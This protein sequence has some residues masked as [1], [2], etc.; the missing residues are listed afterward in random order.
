MRKLDIIVPIRN[1]E[2]NIIDLVSQIN[3]SF[4]GLSVDYR[5]LFVDDH[6]TDRSKEL[7][8]ELS[9]ENPI[10]YLAKEGKRGKA[11]SILE[12]VQFSDREFFAFIDGDLQYPPSFIP[13]MLEIC[14]E[15]GVGVVV[16]NRKEYKTELI[17]K[18][19][20]R[21]NALFFGK[22]LLGLDCDVQSGLKVFRR[23]AADHID[24]KF[25]QP[26]TIDMPLLSAAK[27]LGYGI[28]TVDITFEER[29]EGQSKVN[30]I[31][32][33]TS[34]ASCAVGLKFFGKKIFLLPGKDGEALG[35]GVAFKN[36]RYVTHSSLSHHVSALETTR[37]WQKIAVLGLFCTVLL[38]MYTAPYST[39]VSI[40]AILSS[41]YFIDVLFNLF[42]MMKSLHFPPEL[43]FSNEQISQIDD[44]KLPMYSILCPLYKEANVLPHFV[45]NIN[46]LDWPKEKL[47]VMLLLEEDDT[48][49]IQTAKD[50]GLPDYFRVLVVPHSFPKTKPKACNY[51][52]QH[53]KGDFLVIYDAEDKPEVSQLKKAYLGFEKHGGNSRIACLQAKLNYYNPHHNILTRLFTAEYSLWFDV[54]LPGFQSIGTA[55]PLGGTSNHF[56]THVLRDLKG[57]D[58]FNVTEDADL[59]MRLFRERYKTAVIDST[60]LEEPN[61]NVKNWIRQRSRWIK[62]YMQTYLVHMRNPIELISRYGLHAFIFQL[63]IGAR[64]YFML[65]NPILWVT[66]VS[67]FAL[68]KIVGPTIESLFPPVVFYM[69]AFSLLVGNF[70]AFY[71]YMIGC[72]K[73]GHWTLIKYVFLVPFYWILVSV[74]AVMAFHQLLFKP[75]YWEKTNHGL[76]LK[77]KKNSNDETIDVLEVAVSA[78]VANCDLPLAQENSHPVFKK[79]KSF[80]SSKGAASILFIASFASSAANYI[81]NLYLARRISIEAFGILG[82]LG[83]MYLVFNILWDSVV[84]LVT[85]A[86]GLRAG[87]DGPDV[88]YRDYLKRI[89]F[90]VGLIV[91]VAWFLLSPF[92]ASVFQS[93]SVLPIYGFSPIWVLGL[94][95]AV[96][97]G[98]LNGNLKFIQI[99]IIILVEAVVKLLSAVLFIETKNPQYVYLSIPL[100]SIAAFASAYIFS[101]LFSEKNKVNTVADIRF[102]FPFRLFLTSLLVKF[103]TLSYFSLD[104]IIA[105]LILS[106]VDSGKY[107]LV[108]VIG[109]MIYF[110][111][112]LFSQFLVPYVSN[113][114]GKGKE[115]FRSFATVSLLSGISGFV[116]YLILGLF[117]HITAPFLLGSSVSGVLGH[118]AIAGLGI[119]CFSVASNIISYYQIKGKDLFVFLSFILSILQIV[120]LVVVDHRL[121]TFIRFNAYIGIANLAMVILIVLFNEYLPS[122]ISNTR[123]LFDLFSKLNGQEAYSKANF[124]TLIFNWRD[125]KHTWA[126]GAEVY[127]HE[128]AKRM[129]KKRN[130]VLVFCGNDGKSKRYEVL[131]GVHIVRRGGFYTVYIWAFLYYLVKFRGKFDVVIDSENGIPFFTPIYVKERVIGLIHHVHQDF[132]KNHIV[133]PLAP[134]ARVLEGKIMPLIYKNCSMITVSGSSLDAMGK[135]GFTDKGKISI[136]SPGVKILRKDKNSQKSPNPS[137]LYLGRLKA[138]K[139]ID[140]AI[141]AFA[142]LVNSFP[143]ALLTIAGEGDNREE[144][145]KIALSLGIGDKVIFKGKVSEE[146]K[147]KLLR[148]SWVMV[149]PSSNE[150]WGITVI[151]AN[152]FGTPVVASNVPGLRDSIMNP[153][154]GFLVEYGNSAAFSEAISRL[155][156]NKELRNEMEANCLVWAESH[157]W[158]ESAKK[159]EFATKEQYGK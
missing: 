118:L 29:I 67:Y 120:I 50:L 19:G 96:D 59:G 75:H 71:S 157:T 134:V 88:A 10:V 65:L 52:L 130:F 93:D 149:Q 25:V 35:A 115:G 99:G 103:S 141:K 101:S 23:E 72:A 28:R 97:Y 68:Y 41:I 33:G 57:W 16:A 12:A 66:T 21:V 124:R 114:I 151:E 7:I 13:K 20:S 112:G 127:I 105:K 32:T 18:I 107:A 39:A 80:F 156:S 86:E 136:V 150:G 60:T 128:I 45:E 44:S 40:T 121:E 89:F 48:E 53:A 70:L 153:H 95:Y 92:L 98:F 155:F 113:A 116:V 122:F 158:D 14:E 117:G 76:H 42:V 24:H 108:S 56:R 145:E 129:A 61:S 27:G 78:K 47:D 137:I 49:T 8:L 38:G 55:I 87:K 83:S 126:G 146:E 140:V 36:K 77:K 123:D 31:K 144:L 17:R 30:F 142:D 34:I 82:L 74:S 90:V 135:I 152:S 133:H 94:I 111:S 54:V 109:K 5:V 26:W 11:Y 63:V 64:M 102:K 9:E 3:E 125:V 51:G 62:G 46:L 69:A 1:E 132:F 15:P 43:S 143:D 4:K 2:K 159:F 58:A 73:R 119:F 84:R 138:Y 148:E 79:M 147:D 81:F 85:T 100:S 110:T 22:Y 106:P 154:T 139:S 6:S 37:F 91:S 104:I 131:D